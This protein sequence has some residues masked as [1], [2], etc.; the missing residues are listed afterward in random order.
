MS[1]IDWWQIA[2]ATTAEAEDLALWQLQELGCQGA[3][4]TREGDWV[5]VVGYLPAGRLGETDLQNFALGVCEEHADCQVS[6]QLIP[7]EDWSNAWKQHWQPQV[8]GR[9]LL[10]YPAWLPAPEKSDRLVV[11]LDPGSAFGSGE[12]PTTRMCLEALEELVTP[13][14]GAIGDVGCGSGILSIAA[15]LLGAERVYSIDIDPLAL[16]ATR[17]NWQLNQLPEEG[18][19][20]GQT[21]G[22]LLS[23]P[24]VGIVC[25]ILLEPIRQLLP[26]L[27]KVGRW[28]V[29]SGVLREQGETLAAELQL[30]GWSV[31][32]TKVEEKWACLLAKR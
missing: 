31:T 21:V 10:I 8:V 14:T 6:W 17:H 29:Y 27:T 12:H 2:I 3:A 1:R 23:Q 5:K 15:Y 22:E 20:L 11:R 18:L 25:N 16:Q 19:V 9:S 24:V 7:E 32:Q 30:A 26:Q 28:A 13:G 4:S